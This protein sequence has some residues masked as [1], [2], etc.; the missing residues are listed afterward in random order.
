MKPA[1]LERISFNIW[2]GS[3]GA[4]YY[5]LVWLS[6]SCIEEGVRGLIVTFAKGKPNECVHQFTPIKSNRT[7]AEW[8]SESGQNFITASGSVVCYHGQLFRR[9]SRRYTTFRR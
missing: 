1:T 4:E 7:D 2:M 5:D 3:N 8:Q 9:T 6:P